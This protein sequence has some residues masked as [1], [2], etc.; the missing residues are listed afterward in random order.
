MG[1]CGLLTVISLYSEC[2]VGQPKIW[3]IYCHIALGSLNFVLNKHAAF[4]SVVFQYVPPNA[5]F[6]GSE[7][8]LLVTSQHRHLNSILHE[9]AS[10]CVQY[11]RFSAY[12]WTYSHVRQNITYFSSH[13]DLWI[14]ESHTAWMCKSVCTVAV[15]KYISQNTQL[16]GSEH[17]FS[18]CHRTQ[19]FEIVLH[20]L[21]SLVYN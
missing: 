4:L 12:L 1:T 13:H 21:A 20:E 17:H 3:L 19:V 10:F 15:L 5:Q 8:F 2:I 14:F 9:S 11:Q 16:Y 6:C 18:P 7:H